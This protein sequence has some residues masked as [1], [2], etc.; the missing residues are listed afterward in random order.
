[1]DERAEGVSELIDGFGVPNAGRLEVAVVL[2]LHA[3]V[4]AFEASGRL[5]NELGNFAEDCLL[6]L[7]GLNVRSILPLFSGDGVRVFFSP[8]IAGDRVDVLRVCV[9]L[10]SR[11]DPVPELF[12]GTIAGRYGNGGG[13]ERSVYSMGGIDPPPSQEED[14]LVS[15][16]E[17]G[18][19]CGG[20]VGAS[21][22]DDCEARLSF[23]SCL[24]FFRASSRSTRS[25]HCSSN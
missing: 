5:L 15:F 3:W 16:C 4:A 7:P 20:G 6:S 12:R 13:R 19:P 23:D 22:S 11:I 17:R 14:A 21:L 8:A 18:T 2:T 1:M 10:L 24:L 9:K 25:L